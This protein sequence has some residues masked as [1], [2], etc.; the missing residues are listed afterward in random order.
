MESLLADRLKFPELGSNVWTEF[1]ELA[2]KYGSINLGQGFP[3]FA[4]PD[5]VTKGPAL[6]REKVTIFMVNYSR[7]SK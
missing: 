1:A 3:S 6:F 4:P 5:H 2:A 7:D